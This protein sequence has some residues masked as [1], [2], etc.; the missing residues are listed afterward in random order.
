MKGPISH[1]IM[2]LVIFEYY[3]WLQAP[4]QQMA[5]MLVFGKYAIECTLQF[6]MDNF[7]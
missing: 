7:L 4:F 6:Y 1:V 2:K 5:F 3:N